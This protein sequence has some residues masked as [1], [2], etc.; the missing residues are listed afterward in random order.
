MPT[1]ARRR[2]THLPRRPSSP[3]RVIDSCI[4]QVSRGHVE[5][6]LEY[7]TSSYSGSPN[8]ECVECAFAGDGLRV[9]DSKRPDGGTLRVGPEAW[10]AFTA[11]VV[12]QGTI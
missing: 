8:N 2:L 7:F 3:R 5:D 11:A 10:A 4:S 1:C 12:D 9:R 6:Q